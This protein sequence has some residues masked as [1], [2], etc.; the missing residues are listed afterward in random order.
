M[1][2][3][4]GA[5]FF[6][7]DLYE[8]V[9]DIGRIEFPGDL[10]ETETEPGEPVNFLIIGLDSALGLD[11]NDSVTFGRRYDDRGTHNA[12]SISLL[13]VDPVGGQAWAMSI[14]RDLLVEVPGSGMQKINASSLIG[15]AELLVRTISHN[16]DVRINHYVQLDFLAFRDVV[17][18]LGGVE[19]WFPYP[20]RDFE[21]GFAVAERGCTVLDGR[22][23]LGFV[24]SRKYEEL[25]DGTWIKDGSADLGRIE[26]QQQF[27]IAAIDRAIARGARN[28]TTLAGLIDAAAESVVLDQGLTPAELIDL[29]DAFTNFSS[30]T[31]ETFSPAVV[32]LFDDEGRWEALG[33]AEDLDAPMFQVF[34]GGAD[35]M[36][37][38]DVRFSVAGVDAAVVVSDT[39]LLRALGFSVGTE[40]IVVSAGVDNVIVYPAGARDTAETLARYVVPVP[41][42]VE[43]PSS[44]E[45]TLVLGSSHE[46]ISFFFPQDVDETRAA[47]DA[48]GEVAIPAL[49]TATTTTAGAS[50]TTSAAGTE[51]VTTVPAPQRPFPPPQPFPPQRRCWHRRPPPAPRSRRQPQ[52][53]CPAALPRG[54]PADSSGAHRKPPGIMTAFGVPAGAARER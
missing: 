29:A 48:L 18:E 50:P 23:A 5:S 41:A 22:N 46:G 30:E 26:R 16:F 17:E 25:R 7:N 44:T 45:M 39:E 1:A 2:S 14:P 32:D 9:A 51:S 21:T 34:R 38:S 54:R 19:M 6:V 52:R 40:R 8:G 33:L 42:L 47:I 49:A 4:I 3:A 15:G 13:R 53:C 11:E 31:L 27:V 35:G 24:R 43:D 12:D 10:L 36:S 37:L 20:S 28:P